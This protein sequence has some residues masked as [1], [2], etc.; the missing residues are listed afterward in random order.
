M[1]TTELRYAPPIVTKDFLVRSHHVVPKLAQNCQKD[2]SRLSKS[3]PSKFKVFSNMSP[4]NLQVVSNM[5]QC[6]PEVALKLSF[7]CS[8]SFGS[9]LFWTSSCF[10]NCI[11]PDD[12]CNT[13]N[14]ELWIYN[15]KKLLLFLLRIVS[16]LSQ[17]CPQVVPKLSQSFV[18][19]L[20]PSCLQVVFKLSQICPKIA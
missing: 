9:E 2:P 8:F 3:S 7:L 10:S 5:Y 1:L 15:A 17:G 12:C 14:S 6:F 19:R 13:W 11:S 4:S 18:P 20:S 16:K